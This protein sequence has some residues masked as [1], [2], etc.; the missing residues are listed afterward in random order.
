[1]NVAELTKKLYEAREV[2]LLLAAE[3]GAIARHHYRRPVKMWEKEGGGLV[4]EVDQEISHLLVTQLRERFPDYGH[5]DEE[6][7]D[8]SSRVERDFCWFTD[9]IDNTKRGF[10]EGEGNIGIFL[11]LTY[12]FQPCL[13]VVHDPLTDTTYHAVKR[14][15]AFQLH[16]G[17]ESSIKVS[18]EDRIH[19]LRYGSKTTRTLQLMLDRLPIE[20]EI[21]MGGSMKL[22]EIARGGGGTLWINQGSQNLYLWDTC[23]PQVILE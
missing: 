2:A 19:L 15:G 7:G 22:M 1:M 18:P 20:K 4:T 21:E 8:N 11:G 17:E 12:L 10:V 14:Q 9:P 16:E 6:R 5:V 3:A 13:G 23:G